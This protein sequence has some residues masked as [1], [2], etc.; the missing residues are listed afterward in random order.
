LKA[1]QNLLPAPEPRLKFNAAQL[2]QTDFCRMEYAQRQ[3][4]YIRGYLQASRSDD[5]DSQIVPYPACSGFLFQL[6]GKNIT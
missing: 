6:L 3:L 2:G 1:K 4:T 5:A